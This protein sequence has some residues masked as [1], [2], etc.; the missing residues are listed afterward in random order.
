MHT[1]NIDARLPTFI[2]VCIF[3]R[4]IQFSWLVFGM[5][6]Q[7]QPPMEKIKYLWGKYL[8]NVWT[9]RPKIFPMMLLRPRECVIFVYFRQITLT[10]IRMMLW[11]PW[12]GGWGFLEMMAGDLSGPRQEAQLS[13][14]LRWDKLCNS[15]ILRWDKHCK[16]CKCSVLKGHNVFV[17]SE[18]CAILHQHHNLNLQKT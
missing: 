16:N 13:H 7:F 10:I 11:L 2:F 8:H 6:F 15:H 12:E 1:W 17:S 18:R 9:L 4:E 5:D 3:L 14:I